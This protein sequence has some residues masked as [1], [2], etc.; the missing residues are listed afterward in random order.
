MESETIE[1]A[2]QGDESACH[3]LVEQHRDAVF[4]LAYLML[5]SADDAEDVAQEAF[6]QVFRTL[7]RFDATRPLR[8]WVL[9]IT[10]NQARNRR[11]SIGRYWGALQRFAR[12]QVGE[13]A[14]D[15]E[16][17]NE[18]QAE[19]YALWRA[20]RRL[21]MTEQEV[22]YLR[23]FL[24]LSVDE[25]ATALDV[26]PGTVKS[27]LHRALKQLRLVVER[28]FPLLQEGRSG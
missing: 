5:G 16:I 25:T 19:S 1:R 3:L 14:A 21:R 12:D 11:R 26:A 6:I 28:D 27:R 2:R 24:E 23:Y 8:P 15:V 10:A 20:V 13:S 22:I 4:R 18:R 9:R 7:H 17:Q